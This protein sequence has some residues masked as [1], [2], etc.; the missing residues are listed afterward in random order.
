MTS[1]PMAKYETTVITGFEWI[2]VKEVKEKIE[3]VQNVT[4]LQ[5]KIHFETDCHP[6]K[7]VELRS[8]DNVYVIIG[9]QKLEQ[10][11][12]DDKDELKSKLRD[13]MLQIDWKTGFNIW[14][15]ITSFDKTKS[16]D[17]ILAE[18]LV[19][20]EVKPAF[21][22]TCNRTGE[23]HGFKS[24]DAASSFGGI[25]EDTYKWPVS[26]KEFD[27]EV[28]LN[29]REKDWFVCLCLTP[30]SLHR[31]NLVS[32]GV[33]TL[34]GTVCYAML[35][36]A[37]IKSGDIVC[38]P[39]AGTGAIMMEASVIRGDCFA[40]CADHNN[41]AIEHCIKNTA[42]L[43]SSPKS[44]KFAPLNTVKIDST[45][46]PFRTASIDVIVSDLPF[47]KRIGTKTMNST[48]YPK[49][50]EEMAR[51][52]PPSTG[53]AV[54]LTQDY[55]NMKRSLMLP[56]AHK[57]WKNQRTSFLKLGNLTCHVYSLMRTSYSFS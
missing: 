23:G 27:V 25:I 44:S 26:M 16:V 8:I 19:N 32:L 42:G 34:R 2:A 45:K 30:Q 15:T 49:L 53:R 50:L 47:G 56:I 28:V 46:M 51:V 36:M 57:S 43:L 35:S 37:N 52:T 39:L 18:G 11:P 55:K 21:R 48:L 17:V 10:M 12:Q 7:I 31:R 13:L 54:L 20:R 14:K 41:V 4:P 22:V 9:H 40:L 5:G 33:T 38:D 3:G 29:I 1:F 24:G 6:A